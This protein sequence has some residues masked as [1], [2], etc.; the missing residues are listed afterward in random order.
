[1]TPIPKEIT[2]KVSDDEQT[3]TQRDLVYE[4]VHLSC[5]DETL[6]AMVSKAHA[7]F[8]GVPQE[9]VVKIKMVWAQCAKG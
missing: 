4:D 3:L 6:K 2:I 9:T 1:M 7:D 8:S 5:D